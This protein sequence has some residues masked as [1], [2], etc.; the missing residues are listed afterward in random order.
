MPASPPTSW[1]PMPDLPGADREKLEELSLIY[2]SYEAQL[3]QTAMDPGD[4]QQL[5]A[6]MLDDR[7]FCGPRRVHG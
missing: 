5:A 4:R 7:L 6:Q 3:A 2:G 1:P